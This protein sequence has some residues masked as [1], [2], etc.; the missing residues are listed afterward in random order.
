[1]LFLNPAGE[2]YDYRDF[3]ETWLVYVIYVMDRDKKRN[4]KLSISFFFFS[5]I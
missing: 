5:W 2:C 3:K 4:E 1:M